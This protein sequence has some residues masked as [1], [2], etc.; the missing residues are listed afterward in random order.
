MCLIK[1]CD[2]NKLKVCVSNDCFRK[3]SL[4]Q[5][6]TQH[7]L[8]ECMLDVYHEE[9]RKEI[10]NSPFVAVIADETTDVACEFPLVIVFRYLCKGR[11]VERFWRF[12]MLD[13]HDAK[14][15]AECILNVLHTLLKHSP[16]KL[17][18]QSYDGASSAVFQSLNGLKHSSEIQQRKK[19]SA[20]GMLSAE[21]HFVN[22]IENFNNKV[23]ENFAT[24]KER[25][26]D[27][28]YR[29]L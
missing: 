22:G 10:E 28:I 7:K 8:F 2:I 27:L 26:M 15:I 3:T 21:K 4:R 23:I 16:N 1:N 25:R 29:K 13:G 6:T 12:Y 19:D 17:I 24:K 14:S 18:A 9:V 11:P 20:L 5:G